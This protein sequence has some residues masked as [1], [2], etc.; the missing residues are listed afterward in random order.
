MAVNCDKRIASTSAPQSLMLMNSEFV[1]AQAKAMAARLAQETPAG[2]ATEVTSPLASQY[3]R[4]ASAWQ[5]GYGSVDE[6]SAVTSFTPLPHWNGSS[7]Q[8]GAALPDASLGWVLLHAQGGHPGENPNHQAIRRWT[9][10]AQ[11]TVRITGKLSHSSEAGDG[12]RGRVAASRGGLAGSWQAKA[13][14]AST[15]VESLAVE[16]GDTI[17]FVVDAGPTVT[18]DS[19]TWTVELTLTPRDGGAALM[20]SSAGDFAGPDAARPVAEQ[21]AW[22]WQIA[23]Q[24]LPTSDELSAACAFVSERMKDLPGP[25]Q[26]REQ[27]A[28]TALCQQLL[29]SNEFLYVE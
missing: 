24:R 29:S 14:E 15:S 1:L 17:D 3:A 4:P 13:G 8:G 18:S 5:F 19:F 2:F 11:G 26:S 9:S 12:I 25:P 7:W 6:S 16:A 21:I 27:S 28:L 23:Y 20:W 10:P 22:A